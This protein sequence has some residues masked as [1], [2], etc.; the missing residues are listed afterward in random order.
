MQIKPNSESCT[1]PTGISALDVSGLHGTHI[2]HLMEL[3]LVLTMFMM[4][5]RMHAQPSLMVCDSTHS[6]S[7]HVC[8]PCMPFADQL[9]PER[10]SHCV[11][12]GRPGRKGADP[13]S[14]RSSQSSEP[15]ALCWPPYLH[16]Q[17]QGNKA[18]IIRSFI[19]ISKVIIYSL[20]RMQSSF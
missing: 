13:L 6:L 12:P 4:F 3:W 14:C 1:S 9:L 19:S 18:V 15:C 16:F 7:T 5:L 17:H 10:L 11:T 2:P 8:E 20:L